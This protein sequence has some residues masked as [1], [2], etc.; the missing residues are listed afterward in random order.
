MK[1]TSMI[2]RKADLTKNFSI[3]PN[4]IA[5]SKTLSA[6]AKS[7]IIHMLSMPDNWYYVKTRFW[8]ETNLSRDV[9]NKAWNEL[10]QL[11]YIQSERIKEGN[12]LRG[13]HY[14]ISDSPIFGVTE[15]QLVRDSVN[16]K[17]VSNKRN[18]KKEINTNKIGTKE[19]DIT[20]KL[21]S[22]PNSK[23]F[24]EILSLYPNLTKEDVLNYIN[25]NQLQQV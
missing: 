8:K 19:A 1:N 20:N 13:Y 21:S 22:L 7:L 6:N 12:L 11:G 14:I 10:T 23:S 18:S 2:I 4:A 3:I 15:A 24:S 25:S 5:Q 17:S 9:F 16:R